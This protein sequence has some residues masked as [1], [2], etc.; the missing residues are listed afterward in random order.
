M[1]LGVLRRSMEISSSAVPADEKRD[2]YIHASNDNNNNNDIPNTYSERGE[3]LLRE[4]QEH[5]R[6]LRRYLKNV[7]KLAFA[8]LLSENLAKVFD[9]RHGFFEMLDTSAYDSRHSRYIRIQP[10]GMRRRGT[11]A[12]VSLVYGIPSVASQLRSRS[13]CPYL[14]NTLTRIDFQPLTYKTG[15]LYIRRSHAG[16]FF[17]E[18]CIHYR[19]STL[20]KI[21]LTNLD[22]PWDVSTMC[23]FA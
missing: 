6:Y 19:M 7:I 1:L 18:E 17:K 9:F 3:D 15:R 8:P 23:T 11:S 13:H 22:L 16:R 5:A 12:T 20:P 10:V 4:R 2:A 21:L 14:H